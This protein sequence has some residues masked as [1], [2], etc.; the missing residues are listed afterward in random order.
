[1]DLNLFRSEITELI[2]DEI[3]RRYFYEEGAIAWTIRK[4]NQVQKAI[5]LLNNRNEYNSI[6]SGKSGSILITR[7][8]DQPGGKSFGIKAGKDQ[9]AV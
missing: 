3:I 2:E 7:K 8:N 9:E 6:L 1:V 5:E 4:D